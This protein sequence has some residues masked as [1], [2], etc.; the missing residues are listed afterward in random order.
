[1][2]SSK[3]P[4]APVLKGD[5]KWYNLHRVYCLNVDCCLS[6]PVTYEGIR[7]YRWEDE[8][9]PIST[10][11]CAGWDEIE[12]MISFCVFASNIFHYSLALFRLGYKAVHPETPEVFRCL[13]T[14]TNIPISTV[15]SR[16]TFHFGVLHGS[17]RA[18]VQHVHSC[19]SSIPECILFA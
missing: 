15:A 11:T 1:M 10:W 2:L 12:N 19:G 5:L 7:H 14:F 17:N 16:V 4:S 13:R 8:P 18:H 9:V 6:E 3:F